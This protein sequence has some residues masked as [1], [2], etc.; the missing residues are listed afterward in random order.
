MFLGVFLS[1]HKSYPAM[2]LRGWRVGLRR[3][4]DIHLKPL[5][6]RHR[7]MLSHIAQAYSMC[8]HGCLNGSVFNS[9]CDWSNDKQRQDAMHLD[10]IYIAMLLSF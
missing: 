2:L 10:F 3:S 1:L 7:S 6:R 8:V 5:S 4:T 9:A